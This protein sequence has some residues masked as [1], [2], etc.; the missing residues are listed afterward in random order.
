[1]KNARSIDR[2]LGVLGRLVVKDVENELIWPNSR[3]KRLY[4]AYMQGETALELV[5]AEF[6]SRG[7]LMSELANEPMSG[8]FNKAGKT[9]LL[10]GLELMDFYDS[11]IIKNLLGSSKGGGV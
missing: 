6:I 4:E 1:M 10:D 3:L 9:I 7:Y 5:D 11:E 2:L 8:G